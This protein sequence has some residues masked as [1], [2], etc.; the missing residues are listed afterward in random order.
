MIAAGNGDSN[1]TPWNVKK[2]TPH[3]IASDLVITVGA[4]AENN[5]HYEQAEFSNV[6][7]HMFNVCL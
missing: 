3:A 1:G 2:D 6:C 7:Y 4:F 5:G